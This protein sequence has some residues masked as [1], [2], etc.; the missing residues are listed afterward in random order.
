MAFAVAPGVPPE[1]IL[2][3]LRQKI[4]PVFLPRTPLSGRFF[5]KEFIWEIAQ[6]SPRITGG[7][8]ESIAGGWAQ[9]S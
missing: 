7:K 4:D 8:K 1:T 5:T 9:T 2:S 3:T 6:R